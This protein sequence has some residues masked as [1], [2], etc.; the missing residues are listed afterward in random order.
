MRF[1]RAAREKASFSVPAKTPV[2]FLSTIPGT[3]VPR[4]LILLRQIGAG[5]NHSG[6]NGVRGKE[7]VSEGNG[8]RRKWCQ[9]GNGVRKEMVS[10]RKWCQE[11]VKKSILAKLFTM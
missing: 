4:F 3:R 9:E 11:R 8:V 6:E 10:G 2:F 1:E 5:C 7:M